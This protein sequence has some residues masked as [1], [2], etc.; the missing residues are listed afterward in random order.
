MPNR[1]RP[2]RY[3]RKNPPADG[4]GRPARRPRRV[5]IPMSGT[6]K[7]KRTFVDERIVTDTAGN[8]AVGK[9]WKFNQ[10][11]N[12]TE[13]GNL[14]DQYRI[15][16]ISIRMMWRSTGISAI[17]TAATSN[18][19][20]GAPIVYDVVDYDDGNAPTSRDDILQY[21]KHKITPFG[22]NKRTLKRTVYPRNLNIIFR[23]GVTNG[24]SLAD[25]GTWVD[26]AQTDVEYYGWKA[27][28]DSPGSGT[29]QPAQ[30]FDI[31]YT[32]HFE[33]KNSR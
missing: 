9:L 18:Q 15:T 2:P 30:F 12:V 17:E 16:K 13:F 7:F 32:V 23:T 11:P 1:G 28:I 26:M 19:E 29:S 25:Y 6:H 20:T 3:R 27:W 8:A 14:F 5:M 10:V 4:Y 22:T 21:G 33:C 24:Y 31:T